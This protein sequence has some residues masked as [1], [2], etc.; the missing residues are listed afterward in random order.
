MRVISSNTN[1]K[2]ERMAFAATE[3]ANVCTSVCNKYFRVEIALDRRRALPR[4]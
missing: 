2:K 3:N 1:G 4:I